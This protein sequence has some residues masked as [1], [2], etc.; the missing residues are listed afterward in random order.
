MPCFKDISM[1]RFGR[2]LASFPVG[3]HDGRIYWA[4]WCC[5]EFGGC[6]NTVIVSL[7]CLRAS[8]ARSCGCFRRELLS[9]RNRGEKFKHGHASGEGSPEYITWKSMKARCTNPNDPYFYKYGGAGVKVCDRWRGEHG[10]ENFLADLGPRPKGTTLSRYLDSGNYEPGNVEWGTWADQAAEHR[11]KKA[12]V[13]L[14]AY[15]YLDS[16]FEVAA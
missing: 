6:G 7:G 1:K 14:H 2:L 8:R 13:A 4:C 10:F 12:M 5:P 3:K 16:I 15:H 11:G 9:E